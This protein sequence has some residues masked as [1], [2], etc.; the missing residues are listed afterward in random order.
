M[1]RILICCLLL[2]ALVGC[3]ET[4]TPKIG[5]VLSPVIQEVFQDIAVKP[6]IEIDPIDLL[7]GFVKCKPYYLLVIKA[8]RYYWGHDDYVAA[9]MAQ[10]YTESACDRFAKS[11]VG[12]EG[13]MQ[14]MPRTAIDIQ[15]RLNCKTGVDHID[16]YNIKWVIM[17][18]VCYNEYLYGRNF[19]FPHIC[20]RYAATMAG[21]NG[22]QGHVNSKRRK[23]NGKCDPTKYF[24]N[25][26]FM[27]ANRNS[28]NEQ[29]NREYPHKVLV[30]F[31]PKF[32]QFG[33][34]GKDLCRGYLN[35]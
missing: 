35:E 10:M 32:L 17:S 2:V 11:P 27:S 14:V 26:E 15:N 28:S 24:N 5:E 7:T 6:E 30:K 13:L 33:Y 21:Y 29:E 34:T 12:A 4:P 23:C 31:T 19:E 18:G 25:V 20:D 9:T 8:N 16:P 3:E 1:K 22:G